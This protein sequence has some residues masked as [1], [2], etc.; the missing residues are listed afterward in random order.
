MVSV[1]GQRFGICF[2][3]FSPLLSLLSAFGS[4]EISGFW[5]VLLA[6]L[7][8]LGR[9]TLRGR[10]PNQ[11]RAPL[12]EAG[13]AAGPQ[14]KAGSKVV[15]S[16]AFHIDVGRRPGRRLAEQ[17]V[18]KPIRKAHVAVHGFEAKLTQS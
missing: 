11:S 18:S 5:T 17:Q 2:D 9:T 4:G 6:N 16:F 10:W 14:P 1:P 12:R 15:G 3:F 13:V 7:E 8:A